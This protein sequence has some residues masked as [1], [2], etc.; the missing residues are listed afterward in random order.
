MLFWERNIAR[1]LMFEV[2]LKTCEVITAGKKVGI[3]LAKLS[4]GHA[5]F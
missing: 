2:S 1:T 3:S 4:W 5:G